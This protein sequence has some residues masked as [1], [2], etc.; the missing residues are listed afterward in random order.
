MAFD[1]LDRLNEPPERK[2]TAVGGWDNLSD[3]ERKERFARRERLGLVAAQDDGFFGELSDQFQGSVIS[4]LKG[5]GAT[6]NEL[7]LGSGMQDYF[8]GCLPDA[9]ETGR[10][11][12]LF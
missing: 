7:G 10:Q 6:A 2:K 12:E 5:V 3:K 9:T 11:L 8:Q 1:E 4:A